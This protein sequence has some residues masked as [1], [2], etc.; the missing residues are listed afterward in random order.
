MNLAAIC[1]KT[2]EHMARIFAR[3]AIIPLI[4]AQ[5]YLLHEQINDR[6]NAIKFP[7][8]FQKENIDKYLKGIIFLDVFN[9]LTL[10]GTV[11]IR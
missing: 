1:G 10:F 7:A 11:M 9:C 8:E 2:L 3:I 4:A 6:K 5:S